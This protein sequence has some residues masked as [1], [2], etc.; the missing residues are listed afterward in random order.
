MSNWMGT[1]LFS[2]SIHWFTAS[3]LIPRPG[4]ELKMPQNVPILIQNAILTMHL[5]IILIHDYA[6]INLLNEHILGIICFNSDKIKHK[7]TSC[8]CANES[9]CLKCNSA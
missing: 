2:R 1:V 9:T 5:L 7:G 4:K 3:W 8:V 6:S